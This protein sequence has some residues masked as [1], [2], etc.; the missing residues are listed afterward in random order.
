MNDLQKIVV[1]YLV[2]DTDS[3]AYIDQ[4]N[5]MGHLIALAGI[6]TG[7]LSGTKPICYQLRNSGLDNLFRHIYMSPDSHM[8]ELHHSMVFYISEYFLIC[9][10]FHVFTTNIFNVLSDC[11]FELMHLSHYP[12]FYE[13]WNKK[14]FEHFLQGS[15]LLSPK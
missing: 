9:L 8:K 11:S 14:I 6:W 7:D 4:V 15:S 12:R 5:N 2:S 10:V 1:F 3:L 13:I